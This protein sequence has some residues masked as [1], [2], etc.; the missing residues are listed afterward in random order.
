MNSVDLREVQTPGE[1]GNLGLCGVMAEQVTWYSPTDQLTYQKL[2]KRHLMIESRQ[3]NS[4]QQEKTCAIPGWGGWGGY[5]DALTLFRSP[6]AG[7][8]LAET[9]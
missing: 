6:G 4:E 2:C 7:P 5:G 3:L 8:V 9:R 1:S